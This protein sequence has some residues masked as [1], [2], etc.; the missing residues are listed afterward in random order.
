VNRTT[1]QLNSRSVHLVIGNLLRINKAVAKKWL[2]I[3]LN[4]AGSPAKAVAQARAAKETGLLQKS[5]TIKVPHDKNT[6]IPIGVLVGP[7]RRKGRFMR[8]NKA[9]KLKGFGAAQR[10]LVAE[11]KR[12]ATGKIGKPIEREREA[13][14]FVKASFPAARYRNPTR[15]A[16]LA[17]RK[18]P[19][20]HAAY[21]ALARQGVPR[22][23]QKLEQ[24]IAA[25]PMRS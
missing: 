14:R 13:V 15:Y 10:E 4:A 12:L 25:E 5:M 22:L 3:G 9:G 6:R 16:H 21:Y 8:P 20:I 17:E 19:A 1:I 23:K 7:G 2:N 24:G 18:K 11:R